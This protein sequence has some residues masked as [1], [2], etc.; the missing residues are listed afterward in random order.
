MEQQRMSAYSRALRTYTF[1]VLF[2]GILLFN[3]SSTAPAQTPATS[4]TSQQAQP[5]DDDTS[6]TPTDRL[7]STVA[8]NTHE[9]WEMLTTA[10]HDPKHPDT[11]IQ[12][13]AAFGVM[14]VNAR[15]EKLIV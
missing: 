1:V 12:A 5:A 14:G 4:S 10:A 13:L 9:A 15:A 2:V 7:H 3:F 8:Q 11:R 6:V